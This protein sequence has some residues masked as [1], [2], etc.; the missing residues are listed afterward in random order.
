MENPSSSASAAALSLGYPV[1]EK[2]TR[3]NHP[4]W[5]AQ[6]Q[7][8]LK[9]TQVAHFLSSTDVIPPATIAKTADKPEEQVPNP[10]HEAWVAKDQQ[11]LNYLLSSLSRDILI[12]V[13]SLLTSAAV[14]SA[15]EGMFAS[16]SSGR[17]INTRMAFANSQKG[18]S[19]IAEYFGKMRTLADDM[20]SAGKKLEDEEFASYILAGLDIVYNPVVS[21]I[22][23]RTD[24]ISIGELFQQLYSFEQRI[25]LLQGHGSGS[26]SN[27]ASR[28]G[29]GNGNSRGRGRGGRGR[30]R[31]QLRFF[32]N[33]SIHSSFL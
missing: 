32:S 3:N 6:V 5:K 2:L 12:Q 19:T 27:L 4:L 10:D 29:R 11:I 24:P 20:A 13:A 21:A 7:S 28:G 30:G 1:T 25:S 31:G 8:A 18:T 22:A 9:G 16:Q 33:I 14:W 26:S 17:V 23:A 15:I